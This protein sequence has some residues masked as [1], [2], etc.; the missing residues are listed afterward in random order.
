MRSHLYNTLNVADILIF[1]LSWACKLAHFRHP[2]RIYGDLGYDR[3]VNICTCSHEDPPPYTSGYVGSEY[4]HV[5]WCPYL[6]LGD[7][8]IL[9]IRRDN[10]NPDRVR[11]RLLLRGALHYDHPLSAH[12]PIIG[13]AES[14]TLVFSLLH[15]AILTSHCSMPRNP[16][17]DRSARAHSG[18]Y[19]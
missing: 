10:P 16:R 18:L 6:S 1:Q 2:R 19:S 17:T 14:L 11:H 5:L 12:S 9:E 4:R 13:Y 3:A 7:N 15:I 8:S